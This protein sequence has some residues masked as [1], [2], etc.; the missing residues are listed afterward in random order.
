MPKFIWK[1]PLIL[2]PVQAVSMPVGSRTLTV[3]MQRGQPHLWVMVN[4]E[5]PRE[6]PRAIRMCG[7]G[8]PVPKGSYIGTVQTED[9]MLVWHFFEEVYGGTP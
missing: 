9:G 6:A 1:Y 7:T 5:E 4:A 8:K 2:A 3:Q